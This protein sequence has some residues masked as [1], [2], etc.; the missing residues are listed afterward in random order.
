MTDHAVLLFDFCKRLLL[1]MQYYGLCFGVL[2]AYVRY[3]WCG[4][5]ARPAW[6]NRSLMHSVVAAAGCG[7]VVGVEGPPP[8]PSATANSTS[9]QCS[10]LGVWN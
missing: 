6:A 7:V 2:Y 1:G 10:S 8:T 5:D 4:S 9:V 3:V